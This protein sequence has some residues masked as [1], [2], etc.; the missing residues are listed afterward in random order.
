MKE[1]NLFAR[2][3]QKGRVLG[4]AMHSALKGLPNV[5]G[6]RTLGLAGAVE[7]ASIPGTPGSGLTTFSWTASTKGCGCALPVKTSSFARPTSW[8]MRTSTRSCRPWPTASAVMPDGLV[9]VTIPTAQRG[10]LF[11]IS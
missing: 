3:G 1:E 9:M 5:I 4:D 11:L 7:L 10:G 8:K 6:I 2:A